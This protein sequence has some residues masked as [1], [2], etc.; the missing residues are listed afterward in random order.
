MLINGNLLWFTQLN[1]N[2]NQPTHIIW[3]NGEQD[4]NYH[5]QGPNPQEIKKKIK[6]AYLKKMVMFSALLLQTLLI[7]IE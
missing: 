3:Y 1:K 4:C 5:L 2:W 6:E 7:P